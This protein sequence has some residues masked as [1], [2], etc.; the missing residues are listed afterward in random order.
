MMPA[1]N[2]VIALGSLSLVLW[3]LSTA[4]AQE[5]APAAKNPGPAH[6]DRALIVVGLSGDS[7]HETRFRETARAW[8]GWLTGPLKFPAGGVRVLYGEKGDPDLGAGP[9]TGK[10]IADEVA[11]IRSSLV[12]DGRLW[13]FFLGHANERDDHAYFHLPGPDLSD[14][15]LGALFHGIA[16]KEQVFWM[17]T[18]GSG[19]F[20]AGLSAKGRIVITATT[21]DQEFN[22]TEL[23]QALVEVSRM[24]SAELDADKDGKVSVWELFVRTSEA[25]QASFDADMRAPTEHAWLDDD[26]DKL[27][28]E[29]PDPPPADAAKEKGADTKPKAAAKDKAAEPK[30]KDGELAR[31]TFL[32]PIERIK[33]K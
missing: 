2:R 14:Q 10:A 31:K 17:T 28:S 25:V 7:Q 1:P 23:P 12:P 4:I 3:A 15:E 29:R 16:C 20:L 30:L 19:W 5:K 26:G 22:E 13:V 27:G 18:P 8:R 9:A 6:G 21:R 33:D 32:P 24:A 11:T